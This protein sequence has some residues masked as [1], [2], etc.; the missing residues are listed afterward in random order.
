[1]FV[2]EPHLNL[3]VT[4]M[5]ARYQIVGVLSV[6]SRTIVYQA[7][8]EPDAVPVILKTIASEYPSK[9]DI[10][11]LAHEYELLNGLKLSGVVAAYG[12]EEFQGKPIL[13]L[14]DFGGRDLTFYLQN[15]TLSIAEIL[16]IG[17][18]VVQ[19]LG[20]LHEQHI[21]HKDIKPQ[22]VIFD[23]KTKQLKLTDFSIASRLS[24]EHP[25]L[26]SPNLLEGTLAY[27]SPEQTGRMNRTIDYR[28]DFYSLGVMLYQL[29][30]GRLP[31]QS[32][33]SMEL[34][35]C[36]IAKSP[37]PPH[38]YNAQIPERLSAIILK[39]M[40]KT[41]EERYQSAYGIQADLAEC[42]RQWQLQ[43]SINSFPL[44]QKDRCG[45]FSIPQ[46][47]YGREVE[48]QQLLAVFDRVSRGTT[49]MVLVAGYSGIGKSALVNEVHKPITRQR[50][51]FISGKFDQFQRNIPYASPIQAFRELI[52]QLLTE[53]ESQI[54][55][56]RE[57]LV[58]A[59][60]SNG[61][62]ITDVIPEVESIIGPQLPVPDLPPSEAQ[63]RFNLVFRAF[64]HVF[65]QQDHPLVIFL[66]DLQ[67]ADA[68]SL[69]LI[70]QLMTDPDGQYLLLLGAYRDNEVD[71]MHPLMRMLG[72]IA[73]GGAKRQTIT[74]KP[75]TL[76]HVR[77]LVGDTLHRSPDTVEPIAQ[78]L[79]DKTQ[80]N[81]FFLTQLF[82]YLYIEGVIQFELRTG[83]WVWDLQ[84]LPIIDITENVVELMVHEIQ[85]LDIAAQQVLQLA[86]CVGNQFDL[87]LLA[88]VN[89]NSASVTSTNLW[90]ALQAGLIVPL[91]ADYKIPQ[92]IEA[93]ETIKIA[94]KFLHDRVQQAAYS[95]IPDHDKQQIH[96]R[97]GRLLLNS[98]TP[99]R[100]DDRLFDVVN[101]M[102]IGSALMTDRIERLLLAQLNARAGSKAKAA[103]AYSSAREYFAMGRQL[104][105]EDAWQTDYE[106]TLKLYTEGVEV[107][108]LLAQF[109]EAQALSAIVI[110][111]AQ[112]LID[113]VKIDEL[114]IQF[115]IAENQ[116]HAAIETALPV[117]ELLGH[118]LKVDP[119]LLRLVR[120]LPELG[121]LR[122]YP[123]MCDRPT[124][125]ALGILI[126]I[127]GPSYQAR[128][129]LLPFIVFLMV[130]LCLE[131]GHS[132]LAAYAY[133]MYGLLLCGPLDQ[134]ELGYQSGQISLQILEQYPSD[135]LK[136]KI[137]M[138]FNSF[139]VHWKDPHRNTI[140]ALE[141]T[142]QMGMETG[143]VVY[144]AYC[145]MWS[146]GYMMLVGMPLADVAIEQQ[147]YIDLLQ[148]SKQD[149]GWY[150]AITWRQLTEI[151]ED[152]APL[153][154]PLLSGTYLNQ[155]LID[156]IH[157]SENQMLLFF[158]Y[159]A[160]TIL[161]YVMNDWAIAASKLRR[162]A[163]YQ[164]AATASMLSGGFVFYAALVQL[165]S[166]QPEPLRS[167]EAA[168]V[169]DT[170]DALDASLS[171]EVLTAK[172]ASWASH[173][174]DNYQSKYE[175]VLAETARLRGDTFVA[176]DYYDRAITTAQTNSLWAEAGIAAERAAELYSALGRDRIAKQYWLDAVHAYDR[177][178]AKAKVTALHGHNG[179]LTA[180]PSLYSSDLRTSVSSHTTRL[181]LTGD[182]T[183]DVS[184]VIKAAQALSKEIVLSQ[185]LTQLT[186]LT[187]ENAGAEL[188]YLLLK[189]SQLNDQFTIVAASHIDDQQAESMPFNV[190]LSPALSLLPFSI[191]QYVQRTQES[192][193]LHQATSEGL[194]T[195]DPYIV[196]R[197]TQSVLCMPITQQ[198]QLMG[199]LYLENNLVLGAF[200]PNRLQVLQILMAQAAI[201]IENARLYRNLEDYSN[202][203]E[204]KVVARTQE[205]TE[206]NQRL[207]STLQE[208]Q[209]TQAQLI[210]AEKM[211]SLGQMV[212]GV[213]HEINNPLS[214]IRGNINHAQNYLKDLIELVELQAYHAPSS[215][216]TVQQKIHDIELEFLKEDA[217]HLFQSM[218]HGVDRIRQIVLGLRN[219][220]RL[221]EA[222]QKR[223]DLHEGIEN[224]LLIL[225]HLLQVQ[226][227]QP[228]ILVSK[229]YGTLPLVNCYASMINQVFLNILT[230][231]IDALRSP[232][233]VALQP[234]PI[235]AIQTR[236]TDDRQVQILITDNGPGMDDQVRSK[237][238][239][240][241]FTTKPVG[242]GK[243]LGLSVSYQIITQQ[244]QGQLTCRSHPREG[245]TFVIT[246]PIDAP[247]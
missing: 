18:Q 217:P 21:I 173:A 29:L 206:K 40:A 207:Q 222:G 53:A 77:L 25:I 97:V 159:F 16:Q 128:P 144:A 141:R 209:R 198:G 245:T 246:L 134:V 221:D 114:N 138:L 243:G 28:T 168:A 149:H 51:Y 151:L 126:I 169:P 192:V 47:L 46:K 223:V 101:A 85:K 226:S 113:R 146:C 106:L 102:N 44:A 165:K 55:I 176:M 133:G 92:V 189:D 166:A 62:V 10:A 218:D 240:P 232:E 139:V 175:L 230:N 201:S 200:T 69:Q 181:T 219:F 195:E 5:L 57:K 14:E 49:E 26:S 215:H 242:Q 7:T 112:T 177:W 122:D 1:M 183:L 52:R 71:A 182:S 37:T 58:T 42:L 147:L 131:F 124:L 82:K 41:A 50:G 227:L 213:A 224:T 121:D 56:W 204:Q 9:T 89:E 108:Y 235:I 231:A 214:F 152:P 191:I 237:I 171:L 179:I 38:H 156:H 35:H 202:N 238:F 11:R 3:I 2:C 105:P 225:Q 210:Q 115:L 98:A 193:V 247:A 93:G 22:N 155:Q 188:G 88:I 103:A 80:G 199:M 36:H 123:E 132:S 27:V 70:H 32:N 74:L 43:G 164:A 59:L 76:D 79:I 99:E 117:L 119:T 208:L 87:E 216:P 61:Q 6:T 15:Q 154:A 172:L 150:P 66:D 86:A 75:L 83:E 100:L 60:G 160:E 95:L 39:L 84:H 140:S 236:P 180:L 184:T 145:A 13:V 72:A 8:M 233:G 34:V 241:F 143:D 185:L 212:A 20:E 142:V 153:A 194:F 67:W 45:T 228:E 163:Q 137:H 167:P 129:D 196:E 211:S 203:L 135:A 78:L 120:P 19:A 197:Q 30:T 54:A 17:C 81:P 162:A 63:N 33:D 220:A 96:L 111:Q 109:E 73:E 205:L 186:R 65:T 64:I 161:A 68:A 190:P 244:H 90:N 91:N 31:F 125:A 127:T 170:A 229:Q 158:V 104:L 157:A 148:K 23:P 187:L 234:A 136:C 174:P 118:P 24:K 107:E 130:N 94:Y 12:L 239:D 178:G 4:L 110:E 48:V 116:M